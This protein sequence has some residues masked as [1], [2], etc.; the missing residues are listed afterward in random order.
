MIEVVLGIA[1]LILL[2]IVFKK[3]LQRRKEK[4]WLMFED[5]WGT[6]NNLQKQKYAINRK[7]GERRNL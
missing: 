6:N 7:T 4:E 3:Y 1:I 2:F 5:V